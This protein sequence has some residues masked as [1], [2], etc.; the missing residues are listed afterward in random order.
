M[1]EEL[2][3]IIIVNTLAACQLGAEAH[4]ALMQRWR[5][6]ALAGRSAAQKRLESAELGGLLGLAV[7]VT[8]AFG[9]L[10]TVDLT[11]TEPY[12][13][14][15][16]MGTQLAVLGILAALVGFRRAGLRAVRVLLV[17]VTFWSV[18]HYAMNPT[19]TGEASPNVVSQ[20]N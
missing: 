5:R 18:L 6:T 17:L 15:I 7:L 20:P 13:L 10:H 1:S 3:A 16:G 9:W 4:G 12:L 11:Q 19:R 2:T 8:V 14:K